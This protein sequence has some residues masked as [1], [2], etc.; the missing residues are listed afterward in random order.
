MTAIQKYLDSAVGVLDRF[1]IVQK[2]GEESQL[3]TLLEDVRQIDE[4]RVVA[5]AKTVRYMSTFNE[6]VRDNVKDIRVG[7]RY[8]GITRKFDSIRDDA[9]NLVNQLDDGRID[10]RER[11][12]NWW[13]RVWRGT[14]HTRFEDIA[15][16][17]HL[18]AQDTAE[19]L[20]RENAIMNAY[21]DFRFA[22][23]DAEILAK[24]VLKAQEVNLETAKQK[25]ADAQ[26]TLGSHSGDDAE[27]SR[28]QLARDEKH[29]AFSEEDKRYQ[30]IKDV[31]ENL[32]IGYNVG[33]ALVAKLKQTHDAKDQVYRRSVTFFTTN[34]HVFTT[35]DAVYTSQLGLH[36]A[37]QTT[38][39]MQ[40]GVERGLED[41]ADLGRELERA[42]LQA[43]YGA[44]INSQS[45]QML[46]DSVVNYQT[47]SIQMIEQLREESAHNATEIEKIVEE[48]KEKC[49]QA[50][51]KFAAQPAK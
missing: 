24:E 22:V 27:K 16:L 41:V 37:T 44:T 15:R 34:E 6:L 5:I 51:A 47:E 9:R 39:A 11:A 48:G 23:K 14:P 46:V 40:R 45:V 50:I 12:H 42:A 36:E 19:Q 13:M 17:Y 26:Q 21:M 29:R 8:A 2:E 43:G 28:L 33:E 35:L 38:E 18:V 25:L 7:E 10:W 20:E 3:A 32:S 1:G 49:R 30:L 31:A 4:S